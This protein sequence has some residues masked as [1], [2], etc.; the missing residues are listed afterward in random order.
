VV[1]TT[2]EVREGKIVR[3]VDEVARDARV[4]RET[5]RGTG[6]AKGEGRWSPRIDERT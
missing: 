4:G 6:E 5:E 2:L 3:Q 1:E